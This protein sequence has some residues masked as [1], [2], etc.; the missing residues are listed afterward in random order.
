MDTVPALVDTV[1]VLMDTVPAPGPNENGEVL[2]ELPQLLH[3]R[4]LKIQSNQV[5]SSR[6][7]CLQPNLQI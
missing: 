5:D 2:S 4:H 3:H 6:H 1:P 7:L